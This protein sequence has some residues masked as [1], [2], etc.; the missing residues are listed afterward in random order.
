RDSRPLR[1]VA[2][3]C[4]PRAMHRMHM[5]HGLF[6]LVGAQGRD[7]LIR[8][9]WRRRNVLSRALRCTREAA[10]CASSGQPSDREGG[11]FMRSRTR[12][13]SGVSTAGRLLGF[14]AAVTSTLV[15]AALAQQ[16]PAQ[17]PGTETAESDRT[18]GSSGLQEIIVTAQ[19]RSESVQDAPLSIT[20]VSAEML[21]AR[22]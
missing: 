15:P 1:D 17:A 3:A 12:L 19:F 5:P 10:L 20:A 16:E 22:S 18:A 9:S 8:E 21:T 11:G 6:R 7:N 13:L 14:A 2:Y 4:L